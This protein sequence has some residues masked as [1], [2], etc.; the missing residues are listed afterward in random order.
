MRI[1][2]IIV[3]LSLSGCSADLSQYRTNSPAFNPVDFFSGPMCAWGTVR[4]INGDVS[5]RFFADIKGNADE[6][7]F[8]L[9]EVFLFD[10]GETQTRL[11]QFTRN[12]DKWAGRAGDVV[13]VAEG[14]IFGNMMS[15]KYELEVEVDGDTITLSM[16]DELHLIDDNNLLGKTIM[17]KF[18]ITVGEIDLIMQKQKMP[19]QCK[20]PKN[21]KQGL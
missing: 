14:E 6:N 10:D 21:K 11:W 12:G 9:D 7:S 16:D 5:R 15:L 4:D 2:L 8:T 19:G 17:T 20:I 1:L 3:L 18:G 13:G